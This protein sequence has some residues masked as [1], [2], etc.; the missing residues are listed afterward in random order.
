MS[1]ACSSDICHEIRCHYYSGHHLLHV[2]PRQSARPTMVFARSGRLRVGRRGLFAP[3]FNRSDSKI[4][5][6]SNGQDTA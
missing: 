5:P 1:T 6:I 3:I 2:A 4:N